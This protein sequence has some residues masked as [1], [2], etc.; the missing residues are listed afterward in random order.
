MDTPPTDVMRRTIRSAAGL[1]GMK[2]FLFFI[3]SLSLW[4]GKAFAWLIL[5]LT[6]GV[7]YEVFVR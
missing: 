7:S 6:L 3:D 4:A 2:K 5:V 1:S